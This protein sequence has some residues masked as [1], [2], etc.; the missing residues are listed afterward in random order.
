MVFVFKNKSQNIF[1][2][3]VKEDLK[4]ILNTLIEDFSSIGIS[5]KN[6]FKSIPQNGIKSSIRQFAKSSKETGQ[7]FIV[8]PKRVVSGFKIFKQ[9]FLAELEALPDQ[10]QKSIFCLKVIGS[11]CS[12]LVMNFTT[13]KKSGAK[14]S[15]PSLIKTQVVVRLSQ[16]LVL[17]VLGEVAQNMSDE[18]DLKHLNYF[19]SLLQH[20]EKSNIADLSTDG[21]DEAIQIVEKLKNYIFTLPDN[22]S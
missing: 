20:P 6:F 11:L 18:E 19:R 5:S 16:V 4:I 3:F 2:G 15:L 12:F 22:G 8:I 1:K 7:V 10:K 9:D 13:L 14:T 17:R 21:G